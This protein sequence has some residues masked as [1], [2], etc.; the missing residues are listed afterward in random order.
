MKFSIVALAGLVSAVSAASLPARFS[1]I[2]DDNTP[3]LTDGEFAY[4][5]K[6]SSKKTSKLILSSGA[7]GAL[8]YLAKGAVP[9]AWQNLYIIENSVSPISFTTPHSGS[10][11]KNANTTGFGVDEQG[12]LTQGGRAW[13]AVDGYGDVPSKEVYWYG[14]H[15]SEYKAANLKV[16]ECTTEEC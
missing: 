2:A 16:Q 8:T 15:S 13:F 4:I 9:T 11:P 3:V 7:N 12:Y 14:A 5:G 1:L 6:D 10:V